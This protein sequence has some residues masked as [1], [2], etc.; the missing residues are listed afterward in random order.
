M[1]LVVTD[2]D[3]DIYILSCQQTLLPLNGEYQYIEFGIYDVV[4]DITSD[5]YY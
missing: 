1:V 5:R 2:L 4:T 3:I